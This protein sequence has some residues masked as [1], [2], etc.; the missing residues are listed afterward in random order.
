MALGDE[1]LTFI[2]YK[3]KSRDLS[4]DDS[5]TIVGCRKM[6]YEFLR[7]RTILDEVVRRRRAT[8]AHISYDVPRRARCR[9]TSYDIAQSSLYISH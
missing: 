1:K 3:L 9:V 8:I 6:R 4:Y 7:R 5:M 2:I